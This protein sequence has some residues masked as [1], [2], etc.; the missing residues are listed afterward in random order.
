MAYISKDDAT[1]AAVRHVTQLG[2][3]AGDEFAILPEETQEIPEGWVFFYNSADF[4]RTRNP[5]DSLAGNGP[6]FV[7]RDGGVRDL[8]SAIPWLDALKGI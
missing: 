2:Q 7:R 4:V 3:S 1:L 6:V 5:I 8:P